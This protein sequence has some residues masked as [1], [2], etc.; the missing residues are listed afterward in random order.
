VQPICSKR[1]LPRRRV[2]CFGALHA[3]GI[4]AAML[5]AACLQLG[6]REGLDYLTAHPVTATASWGIF[7]V[8]L[9]TAGLYDPERS[10]APGRTLASA[11][12]A[13]L[14]G[15]FLATALLWATS[16]WLVT[17]GVLLVFALL[18]LLS[19]LAAQLTHWAIRRLGLMT[20]RCL[21]IGTNGE[22]RRALDL[23]HRHPRAGL[24]VMGLVHCGREPGIVGS[25]IG[26]YP[27][28]GTDASL[29]RL[30]RFHRV[31]SL[32]VAAPRE[33]DPALLRRLRSF[34]YRGVALADYVSLHE[35]LTKEIPV[36]DINDEWLLAASLNTSRPH[37]RRLKRLFDVVGS[38]G[39]LVLTAPLAAAAALWVKLESP[40]PVL[41]RQ[42]R[43]GREGVTFTILK[44][45]TM[46]ADAEM[47]TGPVWAVD[48]DPRIT[49]AGR[50]LRRFR[51]DEVPQLINVL[52]GEMS[53]IGPRPERD[54]FV[55]ELE[56]Q[57]PYYAERFM[58][59]PGIT[60][61]AQVMQSYAS[62]IDESRRKL[63]ADLYYIKHMS[64][65]TDMYIILKTVKVVLF[66]RERNRSAEGTGAV[67]APVAA[68]SRFPAHLAAA[69]PAG[70]LSCVV[71]ARSRRASGIAD[72]GRIARA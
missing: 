33:V 57:I 29:A 34:R 15:T 59:P 49:R 65:L 21:V 46:A 10:K 42:E 36:S 63:E 62:S 37:V 4:A 51:I 58:V 53:L 3:L 66:G 11:G 17:R 12:V 40:G 71:P 67:P 61:W 48:D 41:Y 35:E 56:K 45:R 27:V 6:W 32:I 68:L 31:D 5:A 72:D 64:F 25:F 26:D 23:I 38:L 47:A 14:G 9:G 7:W 60:G 8:V 55:R 22:A 70:S 18:A 30:V 2:W 44:F 39:A 43:L 54:A 28:L 1:F 24:R 19:V 50:W 13:V 69:A 52:R 16:A 20:T